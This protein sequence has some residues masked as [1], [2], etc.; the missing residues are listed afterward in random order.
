[1]MPGL[2]ALKDLGMGDDAQT[3]A[4]AVHD[5]L[6]IEVDRIEF[7]VFKSS[8]LNAQYFLHIMALTKAMPKKLAQGGPLYA[9]LGGILSNTIFRSASFVAPE[10]VEGSFVALQFLIQKYG[11]IAE[12]LG[13]Q[14]P[15]VPSVASWNAAAAAGEGD[16]A[17]LVYAAL[18]QILDPKKYSSNKEAYASFK[19]RFGGGDVTAMLWE[20]RELLEKVIQFMTKTVQAVEE[21]IRKAEQVI[22]EKEAAAA[23]RG[24][25]GT[26]K[27]PTGKTS[28]VGPLGMYW[29]EVVA[30]AGDLELNLSDVARQL[31]I[32]ARRLTSV[33]KE[34]SKKLIA[35]I[36]AQYEKRKAQLQADIAKAKIIATKSKL[37]TDLDK[38]EEAYFVAGEWL[39]RPDEER[40]ESSSAGTGL[41]G[42]AHSA[43]KSANETIS[44]VKSG[45]QGLKDLQKTYKSLTAD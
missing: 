26:L 42:K 21:K 29:D 7:R 18:K 11:S 9:E 37:T 16:S 2:I 6:L 20:D 40:E 28:L 43:A 4:R 10:S 19:D 15:P 31:G 45:L 25:S 35:D 41:I 36:K 44:L 39:G 23:A 38:L 13:I 14:I 32:D 24:S 3:I 17:D 1:M 5:V 12:D 30:K 27:K 8:P 34:S 33:T 22:K